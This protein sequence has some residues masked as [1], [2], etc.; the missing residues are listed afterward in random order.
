MREPAPDNFAKRDQPAL[1][2]CEIERHIEAVAAFP[3]AGCS[4]VVEDVNFAGHRQPQ[5]RNQRRPGLP[6]KQRRRLRVDHCSQ[7]L[8]HRQLLRAKEHLGGAQHKNIVAII[9]GVSQN[10]LRQLADKELGKS[11]IVPDGFEIGGFKGAVFHKMIAPADH[12][13]PIL[14]GVRIG[15][16]GNLR[17]RDKTSRI[18]QHCIVQFAFRSASLRRGH[19]FR[20]R[21]IDLQEFVG[22]KQLA[23]NVAIEQ[24]MAAGAPEIALFNQLCAPFSPARSRC[25]SGA[26]S[27]PITSRNS[28]ARVCP[29]PSRGRSVRNSSR[30]A[31]FSRRR[32]TATST[33]GEWPQSDAAKSISSSAAMRA[34]AESGAP[35][36]VTSCAASISTAA[37]QSA[38]LASTICANV[39]RPSELRPKK[40][41]RNAV[42]ALPCRFTGSDR[43]NA[44]APDTAHSPGSAGFSKTNESDASSWMVRSSFTG[45]VLLKVTPASHFLAQ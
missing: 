15:D 42:R 2:G 22:D 9:Q 28:N 37:R 4:C 24:V 23:H 8:L 30:M 7:T 21:Q 17:R 34:V 35:K 41:A 1:P 44:K 31:P 29:V 25:S 39:E 13:F 40:P 14:A 27:S 43:P 33:P 6:T 18:A 3:I 19:Q 16:G 38:S 36:C 11:D 10:R 20:A 32:V 45:S 5:Q 12:H 26:A